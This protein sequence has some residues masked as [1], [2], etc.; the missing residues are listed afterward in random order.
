MQATGTTGCNNFTGPAQGGT[1]TV[2]FGPLATTRPACAPDGAEVEQAVLQVLDGA[3]AATVD[4]NTLE[5]TRP[6]GFGL[7][8][9]ARG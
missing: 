3:V 4:G 9:T 5:L 6:D 7:R 2:T 1:G 8:L